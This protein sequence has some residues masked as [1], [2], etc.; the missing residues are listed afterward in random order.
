M[1]RGKASAEH[2]H[3]KILVVSGGMGGLTQGHFQKTGP[4]V[5]EPPT[6]SNLVERFPGVLRPLLWFALGSPRSSDR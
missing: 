6:P 3:H 5:G 4:A 1:A 2:I